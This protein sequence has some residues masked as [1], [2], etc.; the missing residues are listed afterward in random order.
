[1]DPLAAQPEV[2]DLSIDRLDHPDRNWAAPAWSGR[3][4]LVPVE[5]RIVAYDSDGDLRDYRVWDPPLVQAVVLDLIATD[6]GTAYALVAAEGPEGPSMS[7]LRFDVA[8]LET[9]QKI[10]LRALAGR[11]LARLIV[12]GDDRLA[13]A[14]A[15]GTLVLLALADPAL[16]PRAEL[17]V[18]YPTLEERVE[19][20]LDLA[21]RPSVERLTVAWGD[22]ALDE[23][24][25]ICVTAPGTSSCD[26]VW[27][28]LGTPQLDAVQAP[29]H[30]YARR[31][32]GAAVRVTALYADGRTATAVLPVH[33]GVTPP[34]PPP[35]L[36]FMQQ[37]FADPDRAWGIIGLVP[38][39]L[40]AVYAIS[41]RH[42]R[43]SRLES[44]L[45]ALERIRDQSLRSPLEALRSLELYR[46][47]VHDEVARRRL[48]DS[49]LAVL[50]ARMGRMFR[51]LSRRLLAPFRI[52][53]SLGYQSLLEAALEDG[54][55]NVA[56][57]AELKERL[58][59]EKHLSRKERDEIRALIDAW[60]W[61]NAR[62]QPPTRES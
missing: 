54:L 56:E 1:V 16:V 17:S 61:R 32:E 10:E 20:L 44:E 4:V 41:R 14:G 11:N 29:G 35:G 6:T 45:E 42:R 58:R 21:G 55:V 39:A 28:N 15:D 8:T 5:Q 12:L 26:V 18:V 25:R 52:R 13:V 19:L 53:T 34:P 47:R 49:Q 50:E 7:L 37:F 23:Y 33:P 38:V 59:D 9:T 24:E 43:Q 22:G 60:T 36:N 27:D 46:Q 57:A 51:G 2:A 40:G 31:Q 48:D 30:A 62:L 3:T